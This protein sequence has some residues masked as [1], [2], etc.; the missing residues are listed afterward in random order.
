VKPA[1][2]LPESTGAWFR[3]RSQLKREHIA[4]RLVRQRDDRGLVL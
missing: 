4:A 2:H 1:S 3:V